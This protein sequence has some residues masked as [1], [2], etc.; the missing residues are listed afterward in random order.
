MGAA[1]RW[2]RQRLTDHSRR[3]RVRTRA[4]LMRHR[5]TRAFLSRTGCLD[6][7]EFTLA[8]GVAVGLFIGLTPTVGI[9]TV[10]MLGASVVLR[11]N[12]PAAF[13]ASFLNNPLT[14]PAFYF[15]FHQLGQVLMQ[16]LPIR[17]TS[18][19]GLEDEIFEETTA[20]VVGSLAVAVPVAFIGY[21]TFLYVWRRF[22]LHLPARADEPSEPE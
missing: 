6:V 1:R 17:F 7:D 18:S 3:A 8:R 2:L 21:F 22:D 16:Y 15:G 14:F 11:A 10:L 13:V 20:L 9:Q 12:F 19:P 5:R 4:W